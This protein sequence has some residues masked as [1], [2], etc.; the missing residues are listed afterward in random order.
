[1]REIN[2]YNE[3]HLG[4]NIFTTH[5]LN[6]YV[7]E[8]IQFNYY[9]HNTYI[10]ELTKHIKNDKIILK[11]LD[12]HNL[13]NDSFNMWIG[14]NHFFFNVIS[15]HNFMFDKFY[16]DFYK[17]VSNTLNI[18]NKILTN[19]DMLIDN[20]NYKISLDKSFDYLIINSV[21]H[22]A[23]FNFQDSDFTHLC[24]YLVNNN[25]SFITTRKIRDYECTLDYGMSIVD[26]GNLSNY[27][28]NIIAINTSP[29]I[30]TF[31]KE[32]IDKKK[33]ML[34]LDNHLSYSYHENIF[35]ITNFSDIYNKIN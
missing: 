7:G 12:Y 31:T 15:S 32:N 22:S 5:Y 14:H 19:S 28:N 16:V 13:P 9:V 18:E 1:M 8:N 34:V 6:K 33:L 35:H 30:T 2:L 24:E 25:F 10:D 21:P 26:I 23:Q 17:M 11:P 4:D 27:C 20:S 29:I 3:F